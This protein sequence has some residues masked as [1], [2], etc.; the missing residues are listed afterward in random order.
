MREGTRWGCAA[1]SGRAGRAV[2]PPTTQRPHLTA[3]PWRQGHPQPSA[4]KYR[5]GRWP[6]QTGNIHASRHAQPTEFIYT[7]VARARRLGRAAPKRPRPAARGAQ[8][9]PSQTCDARQRP[10]AQLGS[11]GHVAVATAADAPVFPTPARHGHPVAPIHP[12]SPPFPRPS[13]NALALTCHS[14]WRHRHSPART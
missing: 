2:S 3:K 11:R 4:D 7:R 6:W 14:A 10:R 8:Q 13:P 5:T 1:R 9:P 12:P